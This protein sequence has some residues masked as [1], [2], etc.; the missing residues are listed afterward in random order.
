MLR[1]LILFLT[2]F[3][4]LLLL[5]SRARGQE[6]LFSSLN[7]EVQLPSQECYKIIQDKAGYIWF[8]TDNGLC[9]YSGNK[10][11]VFNKSNGLPEENVYAIFEDKTGKI[12]FATS[13]NRILYYAKGRL[14]E[15]AFNKAY[16]KLEIGIFKNPIPYS[17]DLN[18][19]ENSIITNS[20][21]TARINQKTN[22]V[23]RIKQT[24]KDILNSYEKRAGFPFVTITDNYFNWQG[25]KN[26]AVVLKN[27]KQRKKV[28]LPDLNEKFMHKLTPTA[29]VGNVDFIGVQNQLIRVNA[30]LSHTVQTFPN[31]I[32]SLYTDKANGLWVGILNNGVYYYPDV[33][34]MQL[35][36]HSLRTY[37]VTGICEDHEQGIWCST[38]EKGI[39]YSRN[40]CLL[41]YTATEGLDRRIYLLKYLDGNLYV[42]SSSDKLFVRNT[43]SR[44]FTSYSFPLRGETFF[45]DIA[46][47]HGHWI[48]SSKE[49][50]IWTDKQFRSVKVLHF[51]DGPAAS[52]QL[53]SGQNRLYGVMFSSIYEITKPQRP[54]KIISS[55]PFKNK[56]ILY[57]GNEQL[58]LGGN[59][60]LFH[61]DL[62]SGKPTQLKGIPEKVT[63]LL[64]SHT[65]RIWVITSDDGIYWIDGSN[66][67]SAGKQLNLKNCNDITED[68]NGTIWAAS[69]EGLYC[70]EKV[71][72]EY[73]SAHYTIH[74]GLPSNEVYKVAADDR[75]VWFSTFEGLFSLPLKSTVK[76]TFGPPIHLQKML[77]NKRIVQ[78]SHALNLAHNQNNFRLTFDIL[79]FKTGILNKLEYSL[80]NGTETSVVEVNSNE[81]FLENLSP[82]SYQLTVYGINNDGIRS[83]E[84]EVFRI[85][86]AAPF[87]QT[88]WFIGLAVL[89]LGFSIFL[90]IRLIIRNI[91]KAEKAK[92]L[93][94]KMMAE[95]QITALQAQMNPHFIF[96]AINT[97]QGYI[98]GKNEA[99][100]YSYLAKFSKL[101]RMVLHH[102]QTK[103][104][105]LE[106]ELEVLGLYI[107][108]EQLRFDNSFDYELTI[109]EGTEITDFN[110]PGMLLQPYVEN[111]IWH[112]IVNLENSRRGKLAISI[113]QV[114]EQLVICITDNG[115][116][117]EK[118]KS[119][120][121]NTNHKSVGMQLT[122]ERLRIMNQLHGENAAN[123]K[124]SDLLD[125]KGNPTGTKVEISIP[126]NI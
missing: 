48:L 5:S 92:T 45:T 113:E 99:E 122:G 125:E 7:N 102:S 110:I 67:V 33:S 57:I 61:Y 43:A 74:N 29:L 42:S 1:K 84:P 17:M 28:I 6:L 10:L 51:P 96:N 13:K 70:F 22:R 101:I 85:T 38:L 95:Y 115:V 79:T 114:G 39:Q 40:K 52:Y 50:M 111:A 116:G 75:F 21:Y 118:A 123:V 121:K 100:A 56:S 119:F 20:Y 31:R 59:Q 18:D 24:D 46:P 89:L 37:S 41:A 87:W 25:W 71:G 126:I 49:I 63:G 12:W 107:E 83:T 69:N 26:V 109:A 73:K 105:R 91:R 72:N 88:W 98:L 15:A 97:I 117:R 19:P 4:C 66:I 90:L 76:N 55:F 27:E 47:F 58:L 53:A 108:L 78:Q 30:D 106:R 14:K 124:V 77:I 103:V 65:G 112:G 16:Q 80:D 44:E 68:Q 3:V 94:N 23:T 8:S 81:I 64:K 82:G 35:A 62:K 34:T 60:G 32:L 36:H 120:K 54:I 93:V 9:R 11:I 2:G 104:L 86:I